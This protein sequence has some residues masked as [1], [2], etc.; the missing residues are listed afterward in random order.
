VKRGKLIAFEGVDGSGKSTQIARLAEVLRERGLRVETTCEPTSGVT[1][2]R[3]RAMAQSNAR[4]SPELELEWFVTDRREH[5][6]QMIE[7]AL[8]SGT[9]VLTDRYTLSS[10]AYQGARGLSPDAILRDSEA[11]FPLP[12]LVLIVEVEVDEGLARVS[13]RRGVAEPAFENREF[14]AAAALIF[15]SLDRDYIERIDGKGKPDVVHERVMQVVELRF[16]SSAA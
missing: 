9:W 11:E 1:G 6:D 12:D 3:I 5:V 8:S 7:P 16:P 10:V 13:E 4:V 15:A 2:K 14:L